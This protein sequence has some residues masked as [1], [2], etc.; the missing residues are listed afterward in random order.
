[1]DNCSIDRAAVASGNGAGIIRS[2]FSF[3]IRREVGYL[4]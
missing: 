2:T 4:A 1:M 3:T